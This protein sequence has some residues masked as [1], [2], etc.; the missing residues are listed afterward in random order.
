L[1]E[2]A[3][4]YMRG[5][6]GAVAMTGIGA[7]DAATTEWMDTTKLENY[8]ASLRATYGEYAGLVEGINSVNDATRAFNATQNDLL[9]QSSV[10]QAQQSE[11]SGVLSDMEAGY[12]ILQ[13]RQA[14]GIALSREEQE[15]MKNYATNS[16]RMTGAVEDA[17]VQQALLS[18][19]YAENVAIGDEINRAVQG[20][21]ESV[22]T[23]VEYIEMLILSMENVPEEVRSRILL[24]NAAE[25]QQSLSSI[26]SLLN[27]LDGRSATFYVNAAG[28]GV[29]LGN[30]SGP[31]I[32]PLEADGGTIFSGM[33][34]YA[35]GGTHAI[36]GERGPELVWLPNGAQ[37]MNTE[38]TQSRMR[39]QRNN[40][41]NVYVTVYANSWGEFQDSMRSRGLAEALY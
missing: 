34:H 22:G 4:E 7:N 28:N 17:I 8:R 39:G 13:E 3:S 30:P 31:G 29:S 38:G 21:T 41:G 6:M 19:Q 5:G 2:G 25:T 20:Q 15:F 16:E 1:P 9:A 35:D 37:V 23:L 27:S 40:G 11:Y 24:D 14:E 12:K 33:R 26:V 10:F 32:I 18:G 36:V